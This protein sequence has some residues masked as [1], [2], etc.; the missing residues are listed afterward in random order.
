MRNRIN[1]IIFGVLVSLC[2]SA[3]AV[4]DSE[5]QKSGQKQIEI[6]AVKK[7]PLTKELEEN[8]SQKDQEET[9]TYEDVV[10]NS[11]W[12]HSEKMSEKGFSFNNDLIQFAGDLY[13]DCYTHNVWLKYY[14]GINNGYVFAQYTGPHGQYCQYDPDTKKLKELGWE[15]DDSAWYDS[16]RLSRNGFSYDKDVIR[17]VGDLYYDRYTHNVWVKYYV[18]A[19]NGYIFAQYTGPHGQYCQYNPDTKKLTELGEEEN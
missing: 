8:S 12:H 7:I 15:D 17:F 2:I 5:F 16:E 9:S 18:G 1:T 11:G 19:N 10:N 3:C 14:V 6:D 13:Y 4:S